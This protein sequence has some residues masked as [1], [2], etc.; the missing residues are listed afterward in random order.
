MKKLLFLFVSLLTLSILSCQDDSISVNEQ[1]AELEKSAIIDEALQSAVLD[2]LLQEIDTYSLIG[3]G[4]KS[5]EIGDCPAISIDKPNE[6]PYWP[7][8]ITL[9]FGEGCEKN[10]KVKSGKMII[11]KSASWIQAGS[12]RKVSFENFVV[13]GISIDGE[14]EIENI[15]AEQGNLTFKIEAEIE[16]SWTK[17]DTLNISVHREIS[18]T[19]EWLFGFRDKEKTGQIIINGTSELTRTVN[20]VKKEIE[21][22]YNDIL[23]VLGCRFPQSGVTDFNVK[24]YEG[25]KFEFSLDY[26]TEGSASEKCQANC[27]CIATLA[28]VDGDLEDI[29]LSERWRKWYKEKKKT[30]K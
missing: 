2:D 27:D 14:K 6:A 25:A 29:D 26:G 4:L 7:R 18:K 30:T 10:G 23:V 5:G 15:T 19:Q 12:T 9:D 3:E 8:T 28:V 20:G 11:V 22:T 13:D 16:M 21:K 1:S 24:T 17:N